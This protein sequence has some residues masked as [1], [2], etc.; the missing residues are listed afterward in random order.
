MAENRVNCVIRLMKSKITRYFG[1]VDNGGKSNK[2]SFFLKNIIIIIMMMM[3]IIK[4]ITNKYSMKSEL[5][6][7]SH[8]LALVFCLVPRP[9]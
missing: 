7:I 2:N 9:D 4:I 5:S 8:P 1:S 6:G 3:V